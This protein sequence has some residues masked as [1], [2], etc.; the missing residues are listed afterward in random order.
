MRNVEILSKET[1]Y[2]TDLSLLFVNKFLE[3]VN[4]IPTA[5]VFMSQLY[6]R[7]VTINT[8]SS[9]QSVLQMLHVGLAKSGL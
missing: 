6:D 9:L 1:C 8:N 5:K 2:S 3:K 4:L 7:I